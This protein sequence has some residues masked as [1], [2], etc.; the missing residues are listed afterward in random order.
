MY[1]EGEERYLKDLDWVSI[2]KS[3]RELKALTRIMLNQQQR[4]ILE[5]ER[6][7]VIPSNKLLQHDEAE[8]IQNKVPFEYSGESKQDDYKDTINKLVEEYSQKSFTNIDIRII[9]EIASEG[10]RSNLLLSK[11][12]IN[13]KRDTQQ[14]ARIRPK[15][16]FK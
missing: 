14:D 13:T 4:Q 5:F 2:V 12:S 15:P 3:L 1:S 6:E 7:S 8:L 10:E 9:N 11:P 16:Y